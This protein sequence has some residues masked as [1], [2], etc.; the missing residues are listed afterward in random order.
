MPDNQVE[1]QTAEDVRKLLVNAYSI[2]NNAVLN[3]YSS[4]N[5][6]DYGPSVYTW[7]LISGQLA[8]WQPVQEYFDNDGLYY[9]WESY[10]NAVNHANKALEA[11][12]ELGGGSEF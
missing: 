6:G 12:Q 4:D 2:N 7:G 10:Y 5:I 1:I 8:Y 11:I 9:N 3:E